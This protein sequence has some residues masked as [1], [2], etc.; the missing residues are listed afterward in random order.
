MV[1]SK[2]NYSWSNPSPEPW[3]KVGSNAKISRSTSWPRSK[4]GAEVAVAVA[5]VAAVEVAASLGLSVMVEST[6]GAGV[7]K[8]STAN[9][10]VSYSWSRRKMVDLSD[11]TR[12]H[13]P[14]SAG[15]RA[16]G[17]ASTRAFLA[18]SFRS[19]SAKVLNPRLAPGYSLPILRK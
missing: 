8:N 17:A 15:R 5:E 6:A 13:L 9:T 16:G 1:K 14:N 10:T 3:L 7:S 18:D 12:L 2:R 19:S 4:V 11:Q